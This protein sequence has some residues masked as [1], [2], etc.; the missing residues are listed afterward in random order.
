[1]G[2]A[3]TWLTVMLRTRTICARCSATETASGSVGQQNARGSNAKRIPIEKALGK[4]TYLER[5]AQAALHVVVVD[6]HHLA[7]LGQRPLRHARHA[8]TQAHT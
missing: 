3:N 2:S 7:A 4:L 8:R 5:L 6:K 1:M